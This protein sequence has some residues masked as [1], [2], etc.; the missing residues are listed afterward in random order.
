MQSCILLI[1]NDLQFEKILTI[2]YRKTI[3]VAKIGVKEI[4]TEL[5]KTHQQRYFE[6]EKSP[7]IAN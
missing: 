6:Y 3:I 2:V 4:K 7:I 5:A 1:F